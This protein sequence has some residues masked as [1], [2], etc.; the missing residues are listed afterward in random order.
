MM[1]VTLAEPKMLNDSSRY[2]VT[3]KISHRHPVSVTRDMDLHLL[4]SDG[5]SDVGYVILDESNRGGAAPMVASEGRSAEVLTNYTCTPGRN[6]DSHHIRCKYNSVATIEL[7]DLE[8]PCPTCMLS[9]PIS[10]PD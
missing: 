1:R 7:L 3:A 2:I 8:K 9:T 4:V 6:P 5:V 10:F